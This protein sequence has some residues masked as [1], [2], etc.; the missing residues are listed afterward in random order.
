MQRCTLD[1]V[2]E[3]KV[4]G[5][6]LDA[7]KRRCHKI[8]EKS[9]SSPELPLFKNYVKLVDCAV[10]L[11]ESVSGALLEEDELQKLLVIMMDENVELPLN[12]KAALVTR[13][14]KMLLDLQELPT[15]MGVISPFHA[16]EWNPLDPRAAAISK[17][18]QSTLLETYTQVAFIDVLQPMLQSGSTQAQQTLKLCKHCINFFQEVDPIDLDEAA[19]LCLSESLEVWR[20]IAGI[21]DDKLDITVQDHS[22]DMA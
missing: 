15:L 22:G 9:P 7:L 2:L 14:C 18:N 5:R 16:C 12:I 11:R 6:T 13:R 4:D 10:K 1:K 21:L 17:Q 3:K 19:A 20:A 8:G